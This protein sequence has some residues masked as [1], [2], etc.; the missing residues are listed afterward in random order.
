VAID[1]FEICDSIVDMGNENNVLNVLGG[2]DENFGPLRY[3]SG[4]DAA[5]DPYCIYLVDKPRKIMWHTF[6]DFSFD[7][8]LAFILIK[9][10]L[11]YYVLILYMLSYSQVG[12][13]LLKSSISF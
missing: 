2:N 9:R 8:S 13:P 1:N 5:L 4:Y 10:A 11:I 6:F 7:F 3:F 12:N